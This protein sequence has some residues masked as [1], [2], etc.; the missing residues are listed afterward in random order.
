MLANTP[1]NRVYYQA[2]YSIGWQLPVNGLEEIPAKISALGVGNLKVQNIKG[3][4]ITVKWYECLTC[5]HLPP[6]GQPLC[7]LE[8]GL[9]A[10]ALNKLLGK[11]VGVEETKC[12]GTGENYCQM[13]ATIFPVSGLDEPYPFF[14]SD[15]KKTTNYS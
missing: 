5:S 13:E 14:L 12:W 15:P 11:R 3:D 7:Y 9:L 2:G 1:E 10:G 8:A 4:K 6:L